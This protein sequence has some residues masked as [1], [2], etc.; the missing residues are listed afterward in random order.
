[1]ENEN[2]IFGIRA[3]IEAIRSGKT[4]EK[5][6]IRN[7]LDNELF[8]E[9]FH[10][11]REAKIPFQYVPVEKLN[12]I[13]RKNHQGV[14]AYVSP[15][16]YQSIEGILPV[17]FESGQVPL[18]IIADQ[19]TDVRNFGAIARSSEC[20]GVHA[21]IFPEKGSAAINADAVKTSA[22]ALHHLPVCRTSNLSR[23]VRFLKDSGIRILAAS[24]TAET[25]FT[26]T[27]MKVP[28]AI[29]VGSEESGISQAV[30][31]LADETVKIPILGQVQSLNVSVAAAL[32]IYEAIRQRGMVQM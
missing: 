26:E 15:V 30:M 13:T 11:V 10:H 20:G 1:M 31:Q 16:E 9:L 4:I 19:V 25:L 32:M 8:L 2:M 21:L 29:I 22:G 5:V 7:G 23:T 12:R 28:V 18:L 6:L 24:E 17:L 14:I 27:D 3:L